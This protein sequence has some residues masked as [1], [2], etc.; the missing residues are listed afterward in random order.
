MQIEKEEL[1]SQIEK[2]EDKLVYLDEQMNYV[3][4]KGHLATKNIQDEQKRSHHQIEIKHKQVKD[5]LLKEYD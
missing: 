1:N 3:K 2:L 4:Q 5:T